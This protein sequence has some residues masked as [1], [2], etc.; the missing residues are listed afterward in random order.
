[1]LR[2]C[3]RNYPGITIIILDQ[4]L[5]NLFGRFHILYFIFIKKA[6]KFT[7]TNF[8]QKDILLSSILISAPLT[9]IR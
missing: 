1:M 6:S 5:N 7:S 9:K 4:Y 2:T 8:L 3:I